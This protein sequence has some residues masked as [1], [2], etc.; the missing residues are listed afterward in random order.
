MAVVVIALDG[1]VLDRPVH[2]FDLPIGPGVLDLGEAVLDAV[3][4]A[5]HVEHMGHVSSGWAVSVAW[6][7][8][9]LDAPHHWP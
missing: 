8:G 9:K 3:F 7:I 1:C 2:A 5:T 6:R 4:T